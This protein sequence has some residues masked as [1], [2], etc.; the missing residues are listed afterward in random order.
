MIEEIKFWADFQV[1][2]GFARLQAV[3]RSRQLAFEY[4]RRRDIMVLLQVL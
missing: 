2:Q 4:R 1:H 3:I